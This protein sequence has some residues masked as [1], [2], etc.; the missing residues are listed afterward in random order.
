MPGLLPHDDLLVPE[1]HLLLPLQ[2]EGCPREHLLWGG[3]G[4]QG[5]EGGRGKPAHDG[6]DEGEALDVKYVLAVYQ[7]CCLTEIES[8][9]RTIGMR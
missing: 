1:L 7:A 3:V 8:A 4:Q 9:L 5:P 2:F 6:G